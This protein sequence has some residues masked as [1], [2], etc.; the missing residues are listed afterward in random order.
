MTV[1]YR[2][3]HTNFWLTSS[4]PSRRGTEGHQSH[5]LWKIC[6]CLVGK[7]WL[8]WCNF[9]L[10]CWLEQLWTLHWLQSTADLHYLCQ[11]WDRPSVCNMRWNWSL[12]RWFIVLRRASPWA[13]SCLLTTWRTLGSLCP[14]RP[15]YRLL[16]RRKFD[17]NDPSSDL[18]VCHPFQSC[19]RCGS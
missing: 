1:S 18:S 17:W 13:V 7:E 12:F 6:C 15:L 4:Q 3:L 11:W 16:D 5:Q 9:L 19:L 8:K 2:F 14:W 10:G